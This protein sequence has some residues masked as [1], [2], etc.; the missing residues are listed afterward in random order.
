MNSL[1]CSDAFREESWA[2][3]GKFLPELR[4]YLCIVYACGTRLAVLAICM[5]I[6]VSEKATFVHFKYLLNDICL[7]N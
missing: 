2:F 1:F 6:S 3:R 7:F 5:L 4:W